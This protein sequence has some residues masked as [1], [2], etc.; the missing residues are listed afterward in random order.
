MRHHTPED[1]NLHLPICYT[2]YLSKLLFTADDVKVR[3]WTNVTGFQ[4]CNYLLTKLQMHNQPTNQ[5]LGCREKERYFIFQQSFMQYIFFFFFGIECWICLIF[6]NKHCYLTRQAVSAVTFPLPFR[7]KHFT[8][9][10]QSATSD[11]PQYSIQEGW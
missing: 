11:F 10:Q 8:N 3:K 4:L 7:A 6:H 5:P 9:M 1:C 2:N